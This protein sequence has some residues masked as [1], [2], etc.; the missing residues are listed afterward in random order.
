MKIRWDCMTVCCGM[1]DLIGLGALEAAPL[2][3]DQQDA[4]YSYS[5]SRRLADGCALSVDQQ[6]LWLPYSHPLKGLLMAVYEAGVPRLAGGTATALPSGA[7]TA[8]QI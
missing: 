8:S 7:S 3:V 1:P 5:H 6:M 4:G 2:S